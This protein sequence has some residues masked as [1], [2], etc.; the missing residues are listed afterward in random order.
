ML[1]GL[2]SNMLSMKVLCQIQ[3]LEM[4]AKHKSNVKTILVIVRKK[5]LLI[6]RRWLTDKLPRRIAI[7]VRCNVL[8]LCV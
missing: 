1:L 4:Y 2:R 5:M 7:L 6:V 8:S 3:S